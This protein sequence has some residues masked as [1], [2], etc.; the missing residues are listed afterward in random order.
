MQIDGNLELY[1]GLRDDQDLYEGAR[2]F[3]SSDQQEFGMI[4][5]NYKHEE[6]QLFR[7]IPYLE[8][9]TETEK[10]H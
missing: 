6:N 1:I 3:Y 9:S 8:L 2:L 5:G 7:I 10:L 4:P